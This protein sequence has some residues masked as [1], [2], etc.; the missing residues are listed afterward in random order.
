MGTF[1]TEAVGMKTLSD[2]ARERTPEEIRQ[3]ISNRRAAI[4]DTISRLDDRIHEAVDWRT[5][6]NEH[7]YIAIGV[8][9]GVGY[10]ASRIFER[11]ASPQDRILDALADGVEDI[12]AQAS[13]RVEGLLNASAPRRSSV[14]QGAIAAL[15]T[16]AASSYLQQ[17]IGNRFDSPNNLQPNNK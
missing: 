13:T 12:C 2:E 3:E 16:K 6:V 8:A 7:P 5:Q 9:A 4:S 17:K 10:L 1:S 15:L 11:K 14:F